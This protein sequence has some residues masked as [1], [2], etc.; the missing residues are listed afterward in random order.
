MSA[1]NGLNSYTNSMYLYGVNALSDSQ[2]SN[3]NSTSGNLT[4]TRSTISLL[5][6]NLS[7]NSSSGQSL[8]D[9]LSS[10]VKLTRYAMDA[11]GLDSNS[12]VTFSR[13][14]EYCDK[15]EDEF[16]TGVKD[17]LANAKADL[18]VTTFSFNSYG[19]LTAQ[20]ATPLNAAL[21]QL[22]ID[23]NQET[24]SALKNA[25][26]AYGVD[27]SQGLNFSIDTNGKMVV[28]NDQGNVQ[29]IIDNSNIT[30]LNLAGAI[31]AQSI[32]PNIDF[33]LKSNDDGSVTVNAAD[34]KYSKVLQAFFDE[35]PA[36]VKNYQRSEALSGIED[37]RKFLALS[38]SDMRT[39]LQLESMAAWWD[40]SGSSSNNSFGTYI[41]GSFAR[42]NG[43]NLSV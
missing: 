38:P 1:I 40:T 33:T 31:L 15:V 7:Q 26:Q 39:R 13:L 3:N 29:S 19:A 21:T 5:A 22:A 2:N 23:E 30:A 4:S 35:N 37:A 14:K 43:V 42:I 8:T 24:V 20:S 27:L 41:G 36:I 28:L 18:G 25:L 34:K 32:N 12:R 11:M 10:L 16:S 17:G 9:Q 6:Q